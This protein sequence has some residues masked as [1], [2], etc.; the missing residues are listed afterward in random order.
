MIVSIKMVEDNLWE[1]GKRWDFGVSGG[2][3]EDAERRGG[4]GGDKAADTLVS[5]HL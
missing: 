3:W 1:K 5:G 2:K 4:C